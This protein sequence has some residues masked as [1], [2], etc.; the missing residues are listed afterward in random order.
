MAVVSLDEND[1]KEN[2][3]P[4]SSKYPTKPSSSSNNPKTR[5]RTPLQDITHLIC[6][7]PVQSDT[8]IPVSSRAENGVGSICLVYKSANFR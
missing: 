5:L 1:N 7:T 3:P 4:F 8:T 6:S 2:I